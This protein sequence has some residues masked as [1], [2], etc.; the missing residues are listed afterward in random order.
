MLFILLYFFFSP[1][2][3]LF[4]RFTDS[5]FQFG[6]FKLFLHKE[7]NAHLW[8]I[9]NMRNIYYLLSQQSIICN[10]SMMLVLCCSN[11]PKF[12]QACDQ[13][14]TT[15]ITRLP[16]PLIY[17]ITLYTIVTYIFTTN[18]L[19]IQ[20][21]IVHDCDLHF[22]PN[23]TGFGLQRL[24]LQRYTFILEARFWTDFFQSVGF[25]RHLMKV[26]PETR[27]TRRI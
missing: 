22:C 26:I 14:S 9:I 19:N 11:S 3:C 17:K 7:F 23:Q 21:H 15:L 24:T 6:I 1:L 10:H 25:E 12:C 20:D 8:F 13:K 16:M 2:C 4:L 27:R 18:A 5:D